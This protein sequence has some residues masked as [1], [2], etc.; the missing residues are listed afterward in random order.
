MIRRLNAS[1]A[2]VAAIAL[3]GSAACGVQ[4]ST[5]ERSRGAPSTERTSTTKPTGTGKRPDVIVTDVGTGTRTKLRLKLHSGVRTNLEVKVTTA[6]TQASSGQ[7]QTV[8][9]PPITEDVEL[10]IVDVKDAVAS[11][12][13]KIT[14]AKLD[15]SGTLSAEQARSVASS[16]RRLVGLTAR[17]Q[18]DDRGVPLSSEVH[19]PGSL[20]SSLRQT[21]QQLSDQ[22]GTLS[23]PLP[24]QA[25]A[26]GATWSAHSTL[27]LS[28]ANV[29]V[30]NN[31]RLTSVHGAVFTLA[32]T[33]R[34]SARPQVI[35]LANLPPGARARILDWDITSTGTIALK[36][37]NVF[38]E[39]KLHSAGKQSFKISLNKAKP[40]TLIQ[41]LA[42]DIE[43]IDIGN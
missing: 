13:Y 33:Q 5:Q 14:G 31:Y 43:V 40:E 8:H 41:R 42:A 3:L 27:R 17:G 4:G 34:Q 26:E 10:R 24:E 35:E 18:I 37:G 7:S 9:I 36:L 19:I 11:F 23:V 32:A 39:A 30:R 22:L 38:P 6:L 28:G 15:D 12:E 1:R 2:I 21:V 20:P 25:V 16:L 29:T